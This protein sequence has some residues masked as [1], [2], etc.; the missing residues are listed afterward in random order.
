MRPYSLIK[1]ITI[2]SGAI[3]FS[4]AL[5]A[6]EFH[7]S[8]NGDDA[9]SGKKKAPLHTIQRAAELA[10]PG[11]VI[12]VHEG[13]YRERINPPRGGT[14]D[15]MRIVYQAA[16][17]EKVV[18]KGSEV[19]KGWEVVSNGI[20]KV[21]LPNSFFGDFNPYSDLVE[22]DWFDAK[23]REHHAGT[24]YLNEE[25]RIEAA[26]FEDLFSSEEALWF[27]EVDETTTTIWS[28]FNDS[29]PNKETDMVE[30]K[31]RNAD[32]GWDV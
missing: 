1:S 5:L 16:K 3:L 20:W 8:V 7:V 6:A 24:V 9:A 17:G 25:W 29:D 15:S 27:A 30:G 2:G 10:R 11:D 22:G 26:A 31:E 28:H 18:I 23:D 14:S 12:T 19:V 13:V 32:V 4:T 21:T